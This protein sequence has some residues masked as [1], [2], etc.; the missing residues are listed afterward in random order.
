MNVQLSHLMLIT[1]TIVQ[2]TTRHYLNDRSIVIGKE[3]KGLR[4]NW[5]Q[6]L[7]NA[8]S[9]GL[10]EERGKGG[11]QNVRKGG[12]AA[13]QLKWSIMELRNES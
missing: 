13:D 4:I 5:S 12:A 6:N 11:T 10:G 2:V 3:L 9:L 7:Y 1:G 8:P